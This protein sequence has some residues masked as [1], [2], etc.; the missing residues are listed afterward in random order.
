[1]DRILIKLDRRRDVRR[2]Q[3]KILSCPA[4]LIYDP[5]EKLE[6]DEREQKKEFKAI[7]DSLKAEW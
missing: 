5:E 3:H 7:E 1:M 2:R 4:F 6:E